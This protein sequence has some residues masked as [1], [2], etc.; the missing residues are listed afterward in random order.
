MILNHP[1]VF[2]SARPKLFW[3]LWFF[4]LTIFPVFEIE[5]APVNDNFKQALI[6]SG[7]SILTTGINLAATKESSEPNHGGNAGGA[8]VWWTWTA[9]FTGGATLTTAGSDFNTVV[10]VY[11][12][13]TITSLT[14]I[15][16]DGRQHVACSV[17]F[18]AT[19]GVTY[20]IAVDG[21]G[22]AMGNILLGLSLT[23]LPAND[24][25]TNHIEVPSG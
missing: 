21:Y 17:T 14:T 25:L 23:N 19:N 5:A 8:S 20:R 7:S 22:G 2:S 4:L 10:G 3:L 11:T 13:S 18:K 24:A 12:G 6:L 15:A 9:P 1:F 16:G